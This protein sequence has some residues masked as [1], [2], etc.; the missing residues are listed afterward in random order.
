MESLDADLVRLILRS[1]PQPVAVRFAQ[2]LVC[3]LWHHVVL[4]DEVLWLRPVIA[5]EHASTS[6]CITHDRVMDALTCEVTFSD[7]HSNVLSFSSEAS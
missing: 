2:A 1:Y 4:S 3:R 7:L 5:L 6:L